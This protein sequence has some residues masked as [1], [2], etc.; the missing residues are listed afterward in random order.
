MVREIAGVCWEEKALDV[1][2]L[3]VNDL[4]VVADYFVIAAGRNT[5]QV[6]SIIKQVEDKLA[7]AGVVPLRREGFKEGIWAVLDYGSILFHVFRQEEWGYYNLENLWG[8]ARRV[9]LE[10]GRAEI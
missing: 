2:I 3:D 10:L 7:A 5:V 4:T 9:A 8:D 6:R 1:V